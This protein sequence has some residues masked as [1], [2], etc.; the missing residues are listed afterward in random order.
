[1]AS[2]LRPRRGLRA[3]AESQNIILKKGEIFLE[4]PTS[5]MGKGAGKIKVGDGI[6]AYKNLPYFL[7]QV[8]V[9]LPNE[10]VSF[11]A[12]SST[13]NDVLLTEIS[14][15]AALKVIFGSIKKLL[16]NLT[17]SIKALENGGTH[18]GAVVKEITVAE[19]EALGDEKY[20]NG[21]I[22][23]LVDDTATAGKG[24]NVSYDNT[25]SGLE[26]EDVQSAIDE[27][28]EKIN[29]IAATTGYPV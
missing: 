6:T 16:T 20:S 3:T 14:S 17:E 23:V 4:A 22:Y 29:K 8:E 1:M 18:S 27:I 11:T 5:G 13:D 26:A 2:Y 12:S 28:V 24:E 9:D 25:N 15:G 21:V 19:W 7:E 10:T